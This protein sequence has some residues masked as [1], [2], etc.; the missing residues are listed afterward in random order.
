M[1]NN[2]KV[3][4]TIGVADIVKRVLTEIQEQG[5]FTR[6]TDDGLVAEKRAKQIL[7]V[8]RN[9]FYRWEKSGYFSPYGSDQNVCTKFQ[10][11]KQS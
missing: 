9:T 5:V 2:E 4:I 10:T 3:T 6:T 11:W 7:S 1:E 8:S